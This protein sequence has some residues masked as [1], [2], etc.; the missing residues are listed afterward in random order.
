MSRVSRIVLILV[1]FLLVIVAVAGAAA[2]L[3]VRRPFP[4]SDG[5]ITLDGLQAEV[6]V[7]R[8]ADGVP[9]IYA[10]NEHDLYFAQGYVHAQDRFWQMEFWRH[11]G[12][13]RLAEILGE[14]LVE[15]DTFI[16]T[17]GWNR[18]AQTHLDYYEREAPEYM[19]L[20]EAYSAGVNAY[21]QEHGGAFSLNQ[22]ILELVQ[23][24]WEIE[25]W[26]P[27]DT[28]SWGVVMSWD[29]GGNWSGE[30]QRARLNKSLGEATTTLL[31]PPF[32]EED[33]PVIAPTDQLINREALPEEEGQEE[34]EA[35]GEGAVDWQR[36]NTTVA[37]T[38]PELGL[39]GGSG[40]VGSNSWAVS[41]EHTESGMPLLANDPHL[42]IQMPSIWYENGLHGP[43][44]NV[45]GFSF[46]GV[47]GVILGHNDDIAWGATNVGPD[48]QDLYIEKINP[49]NPNQYEFQ[50]EWQEMEVIE[51][52]IKVN[53]GE[54]VVIEVRQTRHGPIINDVIDDQSDPLAF[55]WTVQERSRVFQAFMDLNKARDFE[56][57]RQAAR[58]FDAPAQNLLYADV[59]GNIGY[60]I[61]GRIP[62]RAQGRGLVPVPGW[63][64][65][66]EWEGYVPFEELPALFNPDAGYIVTAN[67]AV[68]DEEYPH[69]ISFYWADGDRAQR[70]V[71]MIEEATAGGNKVDKE[72]FAR[73]QMDSYS[74]LAEDY[75]KLLEGLSS[76][77][78]RVQGAI[79]R[80]RGWDL[81]MRRDSV[82]AALFAVFQRELA[83]AMLADELGQVREDY[84]NN[85]GGAQR[86]F[87]HQVAGQPQA[88][89]W[90][91]V[92]TPQEET[93]EEIVLQALQAS[94]EWLEENVGG[95]MESWTWGKL[96][97]A[98]F[99]S[100]P[101]G[102]SGNT[103]LESVVNR[104]P[105]AVD[106]STSA[107]NANSWSWDEVAAVRG[108]P[109][110]RMVVDLGAL[111]ESRT[112][113]PTGQSG[114][115]FH[116]HYDDLIELWQNGE[117]HPMWFSQEAVAEATVDQ[118]ILQ[119]A[120]EDR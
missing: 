10:E 107:V 7:A 96:H 81:Q 28:I 20:L 1:V 102:Q 31:F 86:V 69:F 63:T 98:T 16:R 51:E 72:D 113:H 80:L 59:D 35:G 52:V 110:M 40:S 49:N 100:N 106:G 41:G 42:G 30:L 109:S 116:A 99:V 64:G 97:T 19:A 6:N 79:E 65:E 33:R 115:P 117:Y 93:R 44:H 82:P 24:P 114:H 23:E 112:V 29:L 71:D 61:P 73:I 94:V 95:G 2:V 22:T 32:P 108:H 56:D 50:G 74:L 3:T 57:F 119:P 120:E 85:S 92:N 53:G 21:L 43:E 8:D 17:I 75:V 5:T 14:D 101:L 87:F 62:V 76:D 68:V 111:D 37:G 46:A 13:G 67:N 4:T 25:P 77:D 91:D 26:E 55:R 105:F 18:I 45:V 48:V 83:E 36:V 90:D 89:W 9:H 15:S 47:P 84:L 27:I 11:T 103:V 88:R 70:I 118:L 38:V 58:L 78:S 60:Q 54:D 39:S 34:E 104:G 66:Y 12:Q